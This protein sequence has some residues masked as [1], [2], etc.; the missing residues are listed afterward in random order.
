MPAVGHAREPLELAERK[1]ERL[2]DVA[3]RAAAAVGREARDERGVLAAVLLG[4]GDDQLLADL[5]RE[6][7]VDVGHAGHLV[8]EEAAERELR[9]DGVD[10]REAGEVADDRADARPAAA[11]GRKRMARRAG[12]AHLEGALARELE[13]LPVQEEEAGEAEARDQRQLVVEAFAARRAC[14]RCAFG[15]ALGEG[16]VADGAELDVGRVGAV[17]EV[18]VA[19]AEL[20]GQVELAAVG[21]L[22]RARGRVAW[23]ALE[24]L[25]RREQDGLVVAAALRLAAVER[26]AVADR[27]ERVLEAG[28]AEVVRVDVAGRDGGDAERCG[29]LFERGVAAG[30]A[31]LVRAL[32]LDV[33]RAGKRAR[34]PGGGVRVER[35]E[36]VARAA[37]EADEPFGVRFEDVE[38]RRRREQLALAA[39]DAGAGVRVGEDPAEVRVA[40]LG[41]AEQRDVGVAR[42]AGRRRRSRRRAPP[43]ARLRPAVRRVSS[44]RCPGRGRR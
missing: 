43:P 34:E 6:V 29:Q 19:V 4:D 24:H 30:V 26:G 40:G 13:H 25:V 41:L 31:A 20:L 15:V 33:E 37:G 36:A 42:R 7:E 16:A 39:G 1:A 44:S 18:G 10:V 21:D 3:D 28:A 38:R 9:L 14:G 23:Q 11:A 17:G 35:G 32:E 12:A 2:A 27:D 22:A 5:A 8:V